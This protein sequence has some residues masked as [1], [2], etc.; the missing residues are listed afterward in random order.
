M[1]GPIAARTIAARSLILSALAA[2]AAA[3]A[4][5]SGCASTGGVSGAAATTSGSG[6]GCASP[7]LVSALVAERTRLFDAVE[8]G[9]RATL[10][11]LL[12]ERFVFVHAT[13]S[14]ESRASFVER[15]MKNAKTA[16]AKAG[17]ALD[18][19]EDDIRVHDGRVVVWV[20][21]SAVG[22]PKSPDALLFQ[23]TDVL[24]M[25]GG[26][27]RWVS[28]HSSKIGAEAY[29][30]PLPAAPAGCAVKTAGR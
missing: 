23:G 22:R 29:G 26:R 13:G 28:M 2:A 20:N 7:A 21:R 10:E 11:D 9:D 5:L 24:V 3:S 27:W 6:D 25:E 15:A 14:V 30:V 8:K 17:R 18:F 19:T 12:A 4:L 16:A 1:R